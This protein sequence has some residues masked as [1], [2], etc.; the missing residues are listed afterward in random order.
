MKREFLKSFNLDDEAIEKILSQYG[1]DIAKFK[2]QADELEKLKND[3]E[4]QEKKLKLLQDSA[5]NINDLKEQL[6]AAKS[7]NKLVMDKYHKELSQIRINNAVE[8]E[9]TQA[10][11]KNIK[12][13]LP[14]L[15]DFLAKA[16]LDNQ[17][18]IVGLS[19]QIK[20]LAESDETKFLFDT[21]K[22]TT[23]LKGIAPGNNGNIPT[24]F[25]DQ[26]AFDANKNNPDWINKNWSVIAAALQE[27]TIKN[28]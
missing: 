28:N 10:K 23:K 3:L 4:A 15:S 11:A 14:L 18:T 6:K 16:E 22:E 8:K 12:V 19:D 24:G 5:A 13:I 25:V 7:E 27:G 1:E 17:G 26:A 21:G 9:L 20:K 2:A